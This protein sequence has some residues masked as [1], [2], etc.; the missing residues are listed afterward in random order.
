MES[1]LDRRFDVCIKGD[2]MIETIPAGAKKFS[3]AIMVSFSPNGNKE[4]KSCDYALKG[5]CPLKCQIVYKELIE[6]IQNKRR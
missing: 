4:C 5:E 3:N 2:D 6:K 1:I